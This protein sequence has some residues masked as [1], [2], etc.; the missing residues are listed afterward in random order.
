MTLGTNQQAFVD[1]LRTTDEAQGREYL[2]NRDGSFCALGV[3]CLTYEQATGK[4]LKRQLGRLGDT[5]LIPHGAVVRWAGLQEDTA[6]RCISIMND[7]G[8][9]F[10][11]IADRLEEHPDLYFEKS[12]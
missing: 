6:G 2:E 4:T 1:A 7:A 11:R 10:E 3:L 8:D 9:S 12:V 5:T